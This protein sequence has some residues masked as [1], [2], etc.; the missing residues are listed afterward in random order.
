M[1]LHYIQ[2]AITSRYYF[3]QKMSMTSWLSRRIRWVFSLGNRQ[4]AIIY[5]IIMLFWKC[6][7]LECISSR[8]HPIWWSNTEQVCSIHSLHFQA[9]QTLPT[10]TTY[11]KLQ[12]NVSF[13]VLRMEGSKLQYTLY[14]MPKTFYLL[15]NKLNKEKIEGQIS[16]YIIAGCDWYGWDNVNKTLRR[17]NVEHINNVNKYACDNWNL[18][19]TLFSLF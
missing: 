13:Y 1:I 5:W 18:T 6:A 9:Y 15:C 16:L 17:N 14:G 4:L 7:L 8:I 11:K 3:K 19:R 2:Q 10:R 12:F